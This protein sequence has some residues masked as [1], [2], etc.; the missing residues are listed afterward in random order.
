MI[1]LDEAQKRIDGAVNEPPMALL[2][3][4]QAVG[5]CL[6]EDIVA[7][8]NVPDFASSAMDGIAGIIRTEYESLKHI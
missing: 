3:L 1:S 4:T 6:G 5:C 8:F 2:P 7:P